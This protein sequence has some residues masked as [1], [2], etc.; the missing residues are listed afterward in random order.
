MKAWKSPRA[1]TLVAGTTALVVLLAAA[2]ANAQ[3]SNTAGWYAGINAGRS[4]VKFK[5]GGLGAVFTD[6]NLTTSS[7]IDKHDTAYS[8]DLG[9][10]LNPYFALEGRYVDFGKF[11]FNSAVSAPAPDAIDGRFK[12]HGFGV[13]AV[14][15]VPLPEGFAVFGKAGVF[16]SK[17]ELDANASATPVSGGTHSRTGGDFGVGASYD[18]T[19]NF[20][21]KVEWNRYL[22]VGDSGTTG[23]AD[24]DLVTAGITYRF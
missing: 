7:S 24:I 16:R 8:L 15:I 19:R 14:G 1:G 4:D 5:D 2:D 17:A 18:I 23:R 11:G 10:Q 9:Y 21:A 22:K 13:N 6:Q 12:A 3:S 20:V